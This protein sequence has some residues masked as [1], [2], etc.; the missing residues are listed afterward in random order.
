ML[1]VRAEFSNEE[2]RNIRRYDLGGEILYTRGEIIDPGSG[3]LGLASR[4]A[5]AA[6]NASVTVDELFGGK[7]IECTSIVEM[8]SIEDCLKEAAGVLRSVLHIAAHFDGEEIV[9]L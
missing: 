1:D 2:R 3:L 6:L 8:M 4:L 5:F 7:R 9:D